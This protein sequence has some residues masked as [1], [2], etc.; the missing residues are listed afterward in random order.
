[1]SPRA[2]RAKV[3]PELP[4][5]IVVDETS[6]NALSAAIENPRPPS[7]ALVELFKPK[8]NRGECLD[9]IERALGEVPLEPPLSLT[10]VSAVRTR[11]LDLLPGAGVEVFHR[12]REVVVRCFAGG[13]PAELAVPIT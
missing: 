7:P 5:K 4:K 6:F 13:E 1:M 2:K 10:Y 9:A 11:V 12:H 3:L 8:Y